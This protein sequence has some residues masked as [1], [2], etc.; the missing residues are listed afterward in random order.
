MVNSG[1]A[2]DGVRTVEMYGMS[3]T[4]LQ[5]GSTLGVMRTS[6]VSFD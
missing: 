1:I 2:H 6:N 4:G 3:L 5:E